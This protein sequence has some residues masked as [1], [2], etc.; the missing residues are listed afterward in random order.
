MSSELEQMLSR[1]G[2]NPGGVVPQQP[3]A[4][5]SV[6]IMLHLATN[7]GFGGIDQIGVVGNPAWDAEKDRVMVLE[8]PDH[9][10]ARKIDLYRFDR[11]GFI[12]F[13]SAA[14]ETVDEFTLDALGEAILTRRDALA[15]EESDET[16]ATPETSGDEAENGDSPKLD[17]VRD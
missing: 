11:Q 12:R 16:A 17:V 8:S 7:F 1:A 4:M 3:V 5:P 10:G 13:I 15:A 6:P 9:I 14:I 2:N